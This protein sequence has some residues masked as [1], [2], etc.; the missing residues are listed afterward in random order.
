MSQRTI[1]KYILEAALNPQELSL[2]KGALFL[3]A[4]IQHGLI[5]LWFEIDGA[6]ERE[7]RG[8]RLLETGQ[9]IPPSC[10]IYLATIQFQHG[11]RVYHLYEEDKVESAATIC[12]QYE[13]VFPLLPTGTA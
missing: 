13:N 11:M 9:E 7:I 2:P 1:W 8:F 12:H 5:T 10:K 4:Q 6:R 3:S